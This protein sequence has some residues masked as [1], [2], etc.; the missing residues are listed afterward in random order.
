MEKTNKINQSER[1]KIK[2][3]S[4]SKTYPRV[5]LEK[6]MDHVQL[7]K[8]IGGYR[9]VPEDLILSKL[10]L[11]NAGTKSYSAVKNAGMQYGL[12][13]K[14]GSS[15]KLTEDAFNILIPT[16]KDPKLILKEVIRRPIL[17]NKILENY[18]EIELPNDEFLENYFE[19][20]GVIHNK[21]KKAVK[22]FVESLIYTEIIDINRKIIPS[23][24]EEKEDLTAEKDENGKIKNNQTDIIPSSLPEITSESIISEKPAFDKNKHNQKQKEHVITYREMH[25]NTKTGHLVSIKIPIDID[26]NEIE[27]VV[28]FI[29]IVKNGLT[30][31]NESDSKI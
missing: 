28:N 30:I 17:Y 21:V 7:I 16:D 29:N 13:T 6:V 1:K 4:K 15:Y 22:N 19:K 11:T 9:S 2:L 26:Q 3:S 5:S 23:D 18:C 27:M 25:F 8:N 20:Y 10:G 14:E 12:L 31:K 24:I